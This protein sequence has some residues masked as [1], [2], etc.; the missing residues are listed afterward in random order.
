MMAGM[1]AYF[2]YHNYR[3]R[4]GSHFRK[5]G[6]TYLM[7]IA[8]VFIMA[9]LTRHVLEDLNW[10]PSTGT[11]GS[12]EYRSDCSSETP[13]CLTVVGVLFTLVFTYLGFVILTIAT[14][15]NANLV[16][17]IKDFKAEWKRLREPESEV[18]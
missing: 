18:V 3:N 5:F 8:T 1:T 12:R 6:P 7:A 13:S 9:D 16:D 2:A 11:Y 14:L 4:W 10:W 15:W 17:K